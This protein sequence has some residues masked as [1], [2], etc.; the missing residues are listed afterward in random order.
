MSETKTAVKPVF[1]LEPPEVITPVQPEAA[2][3][4]VP[5]KPEVADKVDEQVQRFIEALEQEDLHSEPFKQRLDSAF[6][7]GRQEISVAASLMQSSLMQRNFVGAED[8]PAYKAIS[9]IRAQLDDL[10]PGKE[11]DLFQPRKLLGLIPFGNKLEAY[12]RK[13][14][15]AASQ[16]QTSMTQLYAA[17]DGIQKDVIDIE[18]TR[19]KLWEAMQSLAAAA[20]FAKVLD[21][22][23]EER[24]NALKP[25]DPMKAKALEQEVLFYARQNL[26]DIQT[27]QAVCV[28]GYLALDVLK[29][30]GREMMNGC[31]RV[32]TT[33]MS[34]LAVAQT[35]AR[36]TGNQIQ[37]MQMLQ[38]VN[39]TIGNLIQETG[40]QLNQ[41]VDQTAEFAA[42]PMLGIEQIQS[43]FD[44][45]FQAMDA[46]DNF[47]SKAIETMGQNNKLIAEQ[48][49][50][51]EAYIDRVRQQQAKDAVAGSV[52]GPV[53]L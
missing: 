37:V 14:E 9:A 53:K 25:T 22:R 32:A 10:N 5:L 6:Q 49:Q 40:R 50:R 27:Q 31:D 43:M 39:A 26:T 45:T 36:A 47:R 17:K 19:G 23:L 1:T 3:E 48:L 52:S 2:T 20:R 28:N 29:K 24:V 33:G 16:L 11:G 42:N 41:H 13:F 44:Q 8:T 38:G 21:Q 12:F 18:A 7:L 4:V 51:S 15:S 46:M 35:V 34:A 30:T